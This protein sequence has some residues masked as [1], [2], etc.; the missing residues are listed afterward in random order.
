MEWCIHSER[1]DNIQHVVRAI[2]DRINAYNHR[3]LQQALAM[4]TPN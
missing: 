4:K 3:R 1:F 2:S